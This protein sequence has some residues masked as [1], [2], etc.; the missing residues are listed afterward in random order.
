MEPTQ[1]PMEEMAPSAAPTGVGPWKKIAAVMIALVV[2]ASGAAVYFAVTRPPATSLSV[3]CPTGYQFNSQ[4]SACESTD[5]L[6]PTAV[7]TASA[8][9]VEVGEEV[10]FDGRAST[11]NVG[12]TTWTW[13]F[14]DGTLGQGSQPRK[15]YGFPG[16]YI[17]TVRVAD[18]LGNADAN[19]ENLIRIRV[20]HPTVTPSNSSAPAAILSV[21][22][23]VIRPGSAVSFDASL[24]WIWRWS[25][26]PPEIRQVCAECTALPQDPTAMTFDYSFGD[27]AAGTGANATHTYANA[28]T[29]GARMVITGYN[30]VKTISYRTIHV[31]PAAIPFPDVKNTN[32][33]VRATFGDASNLDPAR[34]YDSASGEVLDQ[35]YEKLI[36]YDRDSLTVFR[37]VLATNV[38][39]TDDGTISADGREYRF[40]IRQGVTFHNGNPFTASDVEYSIERNIISDFTGGPMW[41]LMEVAIGPGVGVFDVSDPVHRQRVQDFVRVEGNDV[42]FNLTFA[43]PPF[44]TL[45]STWGSWIVDK[46]T[47]VADGGWP[48]LYDQATLATYNDD[49]S[50]GMN[51]WAIG[52]GPY[53]LDVFAP[54]VETVLKKFPNYWNRAANPNA[55]ETVIIKVVFET[56]TRLLML[57]NGDADFGTISVDFKPQVLPLQQRGDVNIVEGLPTLSMVYSGINQNIDPSSP[58]GG[59]LKTTPGQLGEDG[60]PVDFFSDINVRRGLAY[61]MDYDSLV[62]NTLRGN[63]QQ[64]RGP[65]PEGLQGFDATSPVYSRNVALAAAEFEAA[66]GGQLPTVGFTFEFLYNTGNTIRQTAAQM[67]SDCVNSLDANYHTSTRGV[68]FGLTY[69]PDLIAGR[70]TVA[71]I[72]WGAD[73][74]DAHNFAQPF[75]DGRAGAFAA[76]LGYNSSAVNSL[77]D[78]GVVATDPV[79]RENIYRQI[80]QAAYD[81]IPGVFLYQAQTF[82]V[83]RSW[84]NGWYWN[85]ILGES[86]Y[87]FAYTKG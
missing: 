82:V 17:V 78:Q 22:N 56:G 37:P 52:T 44:L 68:N 57:Q 79:A 76:Y 53:M 39:S 58:Y 11:D 59:V 40:H 71:T 32:T 14:G 8:D 77:I 86:T 48:Q 61:C 20:L 38:P 26:T 49:L 15:V 19:D 60:I 70:W 65:I 7:G 30:G 16:L 84:I 23:D 64:A 87:Y 24:S 13:N 75:M 5:T 46:E 50:R 81:D 47:M 18:A 43:F 74:A 63:A 34:S 31:L 27:G 85:E 73:Y 3:T 1:P 80:Q 9:T 28:G 62:T 42:V 55:V 29:Y 25:G 66:W 36:F 83:Y 41:L 67:M 72:G 6:S 10:S 2:V 21:D 45:V 51:D 54:Q 4:T 12:V 33:I 69:L 35:V